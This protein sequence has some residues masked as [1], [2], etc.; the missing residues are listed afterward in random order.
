P[1][2]LAPAAESIRSAGASVYQTVRNL[3]DDV[4]R[5]PEATVWSGSAHRAAA[6]MFRRATDRSSAF[7]DYAEAVAA[8][9]MDGSTMI[10]RA[11]TG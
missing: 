7:K 3:G 9:L 11:R 5:M 4:D 8:A 1:E 6:D 2:S 10:G